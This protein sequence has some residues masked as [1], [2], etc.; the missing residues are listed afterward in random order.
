MFFT[1]PT[2]GQIVGVGDG[3]AV[4]ASVGV[5]PGGVV[6]VG[7]GIGVADGVGLQLLT[8][9]YVA[10]R[11][12]VPLEPFAQLRS[13]RIVPALSVDCSVWISSV[14]DCPAAIVPISTFLPVC[15]SVATTFIDLELEE[16]SV[17][18]NL[19]VIAAP[20]P[21]VGQVVVAD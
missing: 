8:D 3:V 13:K 12:S 2:V 14:F 9:L 5:T 18:L 6:G 1:G 7:E 15:W 16:G 11:V 4:G 21:V 10:D 17:L 19:T 20:D